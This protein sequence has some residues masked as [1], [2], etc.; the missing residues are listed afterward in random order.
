MGC[1]VGKVLDKV[2]VYDSIQM[3][4]L[5]LLLLLLLLLLVLPPLLILRTCLASHPE[6]TV[7]PIAFSPGTSNAV[8]L[9]VSYQ[10]LFS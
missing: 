3:Y 7:K 9:C 6:F 8:M 2:Y 4:E 10:I 1:V 5:F